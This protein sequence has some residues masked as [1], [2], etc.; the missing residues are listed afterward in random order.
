MTAPPVMVAIVVAA[1][2]HYF[3]LTLATAWT[4]TRR[5]TLYMGF[6]RQVAWG[7]FPVPSPGNLADQGSNPDL[8]YRQSSGLQAGLST[9]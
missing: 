3:C 2:R 8:H 5:A 1:V 7:G 6:P 4:V 9:G